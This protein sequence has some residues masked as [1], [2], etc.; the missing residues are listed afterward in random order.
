M[1][2]ENKTYEEKCKNF[3]KESKYYKMPQMVPAKVTWSPLHR[4]CISRGKL[5]HFTELHFLL[6]CL[7]PYHS[8]KRMCTSTT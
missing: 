5:R 1:V 7:C 2:F 4:G 3:S 8:F 6:S